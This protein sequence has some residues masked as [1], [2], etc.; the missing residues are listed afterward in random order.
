MI[1]YTRNEADEL[2]EFMHFD[3]IYYYIKLSS[4]NIIEVLD[5]RLKIMMKITMN[6]G[7][8][9]EKGKP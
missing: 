2:I 5:S 3:D 9:Y 1:Y 8:L 4:E 7:E 6:K